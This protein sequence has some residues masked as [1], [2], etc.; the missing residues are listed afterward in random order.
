[1][2]RVTQTQ[3]PLREHGSF[4]KR[5]GSTVYHVKVHFSQTSKETVQDKILRLIRND[6]PDGKAGK[7]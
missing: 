7:R 2:H 5:V 4:Q 1:M 6:T 3:E